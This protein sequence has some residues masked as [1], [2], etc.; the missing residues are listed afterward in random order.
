MGKVTTAIDDEP[1]RKREIA[2]LLVAMEAYEKE[3]GSVVALDSGAAIGVA[4]I[5]T[6]ADNGCSKMN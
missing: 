3:N 6:P 2:G 1:E 5:A 4:S